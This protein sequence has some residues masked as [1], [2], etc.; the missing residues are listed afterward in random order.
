MQCVTH[1]TRE[2]VNTCC[3][4]GTWLCDDCTIEAGG[5]LFCRK[6]LQKAL[7]CAP[8]SGG[9]APRPADAWECCGE[10]RRI[11]KFLLFVCSL[12]LPGVGYM[13]LGLMK[14]GLFTLTS[15]FVLVSVI[16][17]LH[18]PILGVLICILWITAFFDGF[19]IRRKL[20]DGVRV[21]D[22]IEDIAAFVRRNK[23]VVI[24]MAAVF[25][26][27]GFFSGNSHYMQHAYMYYG[28]GGG[29]ADYAAMRSPLRGLAPVAF[30]ALGLFFLA[31]VFRKSR[32]RRV[33]KT[34]EKAGRSPEDGAGGNDTRGL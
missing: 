11:S 4:C 18:M 15:F 30:F 32:C 5:R 13:Y 24:V 31:R 26:A 9:A 1:P 28:G 29:I 17:V 6:C 20:V 2:G 23:A 7:D 27:L 22:G 3:E 10:K 25:L 21:E 19:H 34:D 12:I 16:A 33:L 14:R 8:T